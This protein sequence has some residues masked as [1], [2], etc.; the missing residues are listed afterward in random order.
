[1]V[2]TGCHGAFSLVTSR[3]HAALPNQ[4]H[5]TTHPRTHPLPTPHT[6]AGP[7]AGIDL[8][9]EAP[10]LLLL[11]LA[12]RRRAAHTTATS[13]RTFLLCQVGVLC[14]LC[15][16]CPHLPVM[17]GACTD[18][19]GLLLQS[20][21]RSWLHLPAARRHSEWK[22]LHYRY[23]PLC[24]QAFA[25][26]VTNL[27][28]QD[29]PAEQLV[30]K[31]VEVR[32]PAAAAIL[33]LVGVPVAAQLLAAA[34]LLGRELL[35]AALFGT[36]WTAEPATPFLPCT[37]SYLISLQYRQRRDELDGLAADVELETDQA[38][39][40]MRYLVQVGCSSVGA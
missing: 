9:E 6:A 25:E 22:P 19:A 10:R 24:L 33:L 36:H 3:Y 35:A 17:S 14:L 21:C 11:Y 20:H 39:R 34:W 4:P 40:L 7:S 26:E 32:R 12:D 5:P 30:S 16:L 8:G 38:Q 13:A 31:L 28:H 37:P 23:C 1:M 27:Q 2:Q 18:G 15:P 29:A